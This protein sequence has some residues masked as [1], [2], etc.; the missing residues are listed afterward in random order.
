MSDRE[1]LRWARA[2]EGAGDWGAHP[3]VGYT[4]VFWHVGAG[5][6][7]MMTTGQVVFS[8]D[9]MW[10]LETGGGKRRAVPRRRVD[11]AG[12]ESYSRNI[13]HSESR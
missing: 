1:Q 8:S 6:G 11:R 10:G 2:R 9:D 5:R 3:K 4:P 7:G 12:S 13:P